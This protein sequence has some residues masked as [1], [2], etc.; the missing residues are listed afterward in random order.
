[1]TAFSR[2]LA[3][4][5]PL[6]AVLA[7]LM[8][9]ASPTNAQIMPGMTSNSSSSDKTALQSLIEEAKKDGSTVIVVQPGKTKEAA[10]ASRMSTDHAL[11]VRRKVRDILASAPTLWPNIQQA[12][13][14]EGKFG[15][16]WWFFIGVGIAALGLVL[17]WVATRPVTRG[18]ANYFSKR[19]PQ[20]DP[21]TTADKARYLLIRAAVAVFITLIYLIV[22]GAVAIALDMGTTSSR[23]LVLEVIIGWVIYRL[24]RFGVSWNLMAYDAPKFR[25]INLDDDEALAMHNGWWRSVI[26]VVLLTGLVRFLVSIGFASP[27]GSFNGNGA[28]TLQNAQLLYILGAAVTILI[29]FVLTI[30]YWQLIQKSLTPRSATTTYYQFRRAV[31]HAM[32]AVLLFY[33]AAAF[34]IFVYRVATLTPDAG[35]VIVGPFVIMYIALLVYGL[36]LILIQ[37]LYNRR[38][39]RFMEL[40]AAE[41][42]RL[43]AERE[44]LDVEAGEEMITAPTADQFEYQP[45]FRG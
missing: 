11:E 30:R 42:E 31:A 25:L 21:K 36:T 17:A 33:G 37:A 34:A 44:Q 9:N 13:L 45:M 18:L 24:L 40:A 2:R 41:T 14:K 1:M 35:S 28:L 22:A 43:A 5:L 38:S 10:T 6:M 15:S 32:P 8:M 7:I 19:P 12:I 26:I 27:D 16:F 29:L 3:S 4:L 39:R 23:V 20:P